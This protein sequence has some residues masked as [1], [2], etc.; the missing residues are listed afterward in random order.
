MRPIPIMLLLLVAACA[1]LLARAVDIYTAASE[2]DLE[3]VQELLKADP[4]LLNSPDPEGRTL[5]IIAS[6]WGYLPMATFLLDNG[7][8]TSRVDKDGRSALHWAAGTGRRTVV[9][10]LLEHEID[11][12][13]KERAGRTAQQFAIDEKQSEM[14][15]LIADYVKK[16]TVVI[17]PGLLGAKQKAVL[18]GL[19]AAQYVTL[20]WSPVEL[21]PEIV[22]VGRP[23]TLANDCRR[24]KARGLSV[25]LVE[26]ALRK[27][28]TRGIQAVVVDV[29]GHPRAAV[30]VE[31]LGEPAARENDEYRDP[32]QPDAPAKPLTW[33]KY[34]WLQ[35]GVV[36][37][38][39]RVVRVDCPLLQAARLA[40]LPK[41]GQVIV[42]PKD[43]AEAVYVPEGEFIMGNDRGD[44]DERPTHKVALDAF[45]IYKREVTV[46]QYRQFCKETNRPLFVQPA[47]A[48]DNHP[49]VNISWEDAA[50]YA[51]WAGGRLP[52]EA[53]WEKAARGT[54]GRIYPW[55]N[56]EDAGLA[57][58]EGRVGATV[59][60]GSFPEDRSPYG[61]LD[62]AGNAREMVADW[63]APDC[64]QPSTD[65]NPTG[66]PSGLVHLQRGGN[67]HG[68]VWAGSRCA[69]RSDPPPVGASIAKRWTDVGFRIAH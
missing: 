28:N 52:T 19:G 55:G 53:E 38:G 37:D 67:Y 29:T 5:L 17:P 3:S 26:L 31:A 42:N 63:F 18:G 48:T 4:K 40:L 22:A 30:I 57:N 41:P 59:A 49:V 10:A 13:L 39:V 9:Q 11:I 60:V 45:W 14:A 2:N 21:T 32:A 7:A 36:E 24:L 56:A 15:K 50:A 51:A 25:G 65:R 6:A 62:M 61:C 20:S 58:V 68:A 44:A 66:P 47:Y 8:E 43:N 46:A 34:D 23:E 33:L 35:F 27:A 12:T 54:D 69:A 1:P 16:T 64:H